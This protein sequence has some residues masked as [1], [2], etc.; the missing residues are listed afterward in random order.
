MVAP[1]DND[2]LWARALHFQHN[3]SPALCGVSLG[4]REGGV[5]AVT[6]PRGSGETTLLPCLAGRL[7]D[8]RGEVSYNGTPVHTMA[9]LTRERVGRDRYSCADPVAL[10][11]PELNAWE[12]AA[13]P[14][15][16]RG[17]SRRRAKAATLEWLERLDV[18]DHAL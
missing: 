13:L 8:E 16:L 2:V 11:V 14:L 17:T 9:Q 18:G 7:P 3:G 5:L 10:L 15:M 1:P 6:G 4:L 12:N